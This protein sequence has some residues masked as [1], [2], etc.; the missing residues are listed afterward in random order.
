MLAHA[1]DPEDG[2]VHFDED[3]TFTDSTA[4]GISLLANAVHEFGHALGLD[5]SGVQSA[6]MY[7]F[8]TPGKAANL[9]QDD[10]NGIRA[11]YGK[12]V[13]IG[14]VTSSLC[15][16]AV[17]LVMYCVT[18]Y[19]NVFLLWVLTSYEVYGSVIAFV[20]CISK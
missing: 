2:R 8:Y 6:V 11:I 7:A 3:Q 9:D 18:N 13:C 14:Q 5:H 19:P 17:C 20:I 12:H 10:I 15:L 1:Y 4:Q 16:L